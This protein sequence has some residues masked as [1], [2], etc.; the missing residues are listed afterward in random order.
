MKMAFEMLD[1]TYSG[2]TSYT[3]GLRYED[4]TIG[5]DSRIWMKLVIGLRPDR[6][7]PR[8]ARTSGPSIRRIIEESLE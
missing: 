6:P 2:Q 1:P 4:I 7:T 5:P 8:G 3:D